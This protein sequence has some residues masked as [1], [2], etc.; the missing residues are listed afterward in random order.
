LTIDESTIDDGDRVTTN[1]HPTGLDHLVIVTPDVERALAFYCGTLGLE[2]LRVEEWRR[3][4]VLFPSARI[5]ATT[6]VDFLAGER[7][8]ENV[9]HVALVIE[10]TDLDTL[11]ESGVFE[12]VGGPADL[13][14]AQ[15]QGRGIYV[16]DP[17][18]NTVELRHY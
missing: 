2:P 13:F 14:G 3:G 11:A 5:D 7:T 16:R 1:V 10:P 4:E 12:V 8:G 9:N 18:G 6:I 15:G 17:D